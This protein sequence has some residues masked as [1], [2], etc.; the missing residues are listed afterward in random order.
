MKRNEAIV[1]LI[2]Y[3]DKLIDL[4]LCRTEKRHQIQ[5]VTYFL[6]P[7][8]Q[9]ETIDVHTRTWIPYL[10]PAIGKLRSREMHDSS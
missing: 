8:E 1:K 10:R 2:F 5:V 4:D 6:A 9:G 7:V 3:L